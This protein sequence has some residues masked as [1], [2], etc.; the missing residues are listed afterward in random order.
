MAREP[1]MTAS[2][3]RSLIIEKL[4][5]IDG[6]STGDAFE[7]GSLVDRYGNVRGAEILNPFFDTLM[8]TIDKPK[9]VDGDGWKAGA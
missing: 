7:L 8:K 9:P 1:D 4:M 3:I 5:T 2:Q 6:I